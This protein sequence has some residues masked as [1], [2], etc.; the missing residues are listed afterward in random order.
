MKQQRELINLSGKGANQ[1]SKWASGKKLA[2]LSPNREISDCMFIAL[3]ALFTLV[4]SLA[5]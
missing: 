2:M 3:C 5:R 1:A 4:L